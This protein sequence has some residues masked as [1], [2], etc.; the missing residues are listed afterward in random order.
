MDEK[1]LQASGPPGGKAIGEAAVP[2]GTTAFDKPL[3]GE[4][5]K[6]AINRSAIRRRAEPPA[7]LVGLKESA[8][9]GEYC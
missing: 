7:H 4:P 3:L 5:N 6:V 2:A 8:I 9:P 1:I